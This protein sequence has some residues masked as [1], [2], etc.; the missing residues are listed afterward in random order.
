MVMSCIQ[1]HIQQIYNDPCY[2]WFADCLF[3][4]TV[5]TASRMES[6]S[7]PGR[8]HCSE[9]SYKALKATSPDILCEKRT[10][11]GAIKGK[12]KMNTYWVLGRA[13]L[14]SSSRA[15]DVLANLPPGESVLEVTD[16]NA[17]S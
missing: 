4:D 11:L 1:L 5:N 6:T 2:C 7:Q 8:V 10:D 9:A 12:G 3:G 17:P 13:L 16:I 14:S 15:M